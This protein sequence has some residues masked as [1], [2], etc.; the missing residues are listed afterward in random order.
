MYSWFAWTHP[1]TCTCTVHSTPESRYLCTL[2]L[3]GGYFLPWSD[4]SAY[5]R[6]TTCQHG[7]FVY[8]ALLIIIRIGNSKSMH[9]KLCRTCLRH[10]AAQ[11]S[12][13]VFKLMP[14][15]PSPICMQLTESINC[16]WR[17]SPTIFYILLVRQWVIHIYFIIIFL[18]LTSIFNTILL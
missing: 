2:S 6:I 12:L 7:I 5:V 15:V 9:V 17:L 4:I 1:H 14:A 3:I 18:R 16:L 13:Q 8:H 11:Q 10:S